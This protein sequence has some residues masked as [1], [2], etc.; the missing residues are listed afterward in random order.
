[1]LVAVNRAERQ[2]PDEHLNENESGERVVQELSS[3][4]PSRLPPTDQPVAR[5][6]SDRREKRQR[7]AQVLRL[8]CPRRERIGDH[9]RDQQ[10]ADEYL[11][12]LDSQ[13]QATVSRAAPGEDAHRG[14]ER[15]DR[16][17]RGQ[18]RED[19]PDSPARELHDLVD[20]WHRAHV[21]S[22]VRD[23][24]FASRDL[25]FAQDIVDHGNRIGDTIRFEECECEN[26]G[27]EHDRPR[28]ATKDRSEW[29]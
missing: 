18:Q 24:E 8:A 6:D 26:S 20:D 10:E 27:Y 5:Q 12:T 19:G 14:D 22:R 25:P 13:L 16:S 23:I 28:R 7:V 29:R 4:S 11:V 9:P 2:G 1:M 21:L 15:A 3:S 17:E